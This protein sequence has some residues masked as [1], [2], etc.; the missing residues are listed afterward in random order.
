[1][2][3]VLNENDKRVML[4]DKNGVPYCGMSYD[5]AFNLVTE[6]SL[7]LADKLVTVEDGDAEDSYLSGDFE[8]KEARAQE[9]LSRNTEQGL[10]FNEVI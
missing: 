1:M 7:I 3:Y 5:E 9:Q 6:L 4:V 2:R 10:P 8:E